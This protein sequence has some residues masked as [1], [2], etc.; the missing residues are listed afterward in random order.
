M[1]NSIDSKKKKNNKF[2]YIK[3]VP[4][5]IEW[6]HYQENTWKIFRYFYIN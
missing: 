2:K 5:V 6:T 1:N 3:G 4:E